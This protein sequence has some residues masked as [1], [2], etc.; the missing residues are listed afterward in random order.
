VR[1]PLAVCA[2]LLGAACGQ[3][4]STGPGPGQGQF[5]YVDN[6]YLGQ[7]DIYI[8]NA[9]AKGRAQLT[10][11]LADDWWPTWSPD[12]SKIA[13]Q[14][15]R[16]LTP[17][18]TIP[19]HP[20]LDI[21]VINVTGTGETQLTSDTT[22]EAQPAWSPN[23]DRIAFTTERTG[24]PE[25]WVMDSTGANPV[26]LTNNAATDLAPAWSPDGTQIAF[27]S[28]RA[29]D[30][31]IFVMN[32]DGSNVRQLT[33]AGVPDEL[34]AWSPDGKRIVYDSDGDLWVYW[35]DGSGQSQVT[36]S[37]YVLDFNARWRP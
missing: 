34:P 3:D 5:A 22:N 33:N 8:I 17:G 37:K 30:F 21:Y 25:I 4:T 23:G 27:M 20:E 28:D 15:N 26:Q 12:G 1:R 24:N 31:A 11:N 9:D 29:G 19:A 18:D 6:S 36:K 2:A 7:W 10:T 16:N 13:F 35:M 32:S 14:S